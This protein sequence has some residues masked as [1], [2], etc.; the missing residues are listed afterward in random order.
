MDLKRRFIFDCGLCRGSGGFLVV[1]SE[2]KSLP[3][4]GFGPGLFTV[5]F[6]DRPGGDLF[7]PFPIPAGTLRRGLDMFV[8]TLLFR[9]DA[10]EMFASWHNDRDSRATFNCD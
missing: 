2:I 6:E 1:C 5:L 10:F 9:T 8:L 7:G 3:S 4:A